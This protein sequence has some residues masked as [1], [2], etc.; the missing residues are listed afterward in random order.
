MTTGKP[1]Q[2]RAVRKQ[3]SRPRQF[4][5]QTIQIRRSWRCLVPELGKEISPHR[6]TLAHGRQRH[7]RE[8]YCWRGSGDYTTVIV[9]AIGPSLPVTGKLANP[10]WNFIMPIGSTLGFNDN[11]SDT[12]QAEIIA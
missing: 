5:Q 10:F 1:D 8:D 11:W 7:H 12:Q 9:R 4:R 6:R 2:M 3:T